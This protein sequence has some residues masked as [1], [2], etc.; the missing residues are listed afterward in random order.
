MLKV[1]IFALLAAVAVVL[2]RQFKSD[3]ALAVAVCSGIAL[4]AVA[5]ESL[6]DVV[7]SMYGLSSAAGLDGQSVACVVKVVGI[8]YVA[9]FTDNVCRDAEVKGVGDKVLL[10][11]KVAILLC[12]LPVV[13]QL[14]SL[15]SEVAL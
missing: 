6:F 13:K 3:L 8:G 14:F 10:A 15:L 11:G 1:V 7:Y 9:E 12:V 4:T 2:L 5:C